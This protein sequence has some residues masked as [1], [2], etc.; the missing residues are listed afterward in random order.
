VNTYQKIGTFIFRLFGCGVFFF[1]AMG[2][3]YAGVQKLCALNVPV[4]SSEQFIGSIF[5]VIGGMFLFVIA[6]LVG[7]VIGAG[8]G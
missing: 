2:L 1:G 8:L 5:W 6:R 3:V 4:Y 7:K